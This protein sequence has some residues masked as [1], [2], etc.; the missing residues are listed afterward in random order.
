M[1]PNHEQIVKFKRQIKKIY[2][3]ARDVMKRIVVILVMKLLLGLTLKKVLAEPS[4]DTHA[5]S[6]DTY[7]P[8]KRRHIKM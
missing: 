5:Q 1:T 8:T 2:R 6:K 3:I 7:N 4:E